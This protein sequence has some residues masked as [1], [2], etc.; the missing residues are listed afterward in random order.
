MSRYRPS[1][2]GD[3]AYIGEYSNRVHI[4]P[5]GVSVEVAADYRRWA[6]EAADGFTRTMWT[7]MADELE[8][9]IKEARTI[10][11]AS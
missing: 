11:V 2:T 6:D 4:I 5:L 9:A 3:V 1:T 10:R 7:A 8:A